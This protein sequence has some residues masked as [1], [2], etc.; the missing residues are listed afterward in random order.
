MYFTHQIMV[1]YVASVLKKKRGGKIKA[2]QLVTL[3]NKGLQP[4]ERQTL[5]RVGRPIYNQSL[6]VLYCTDYRN[7]K[8]KKICLC[9]ILLL[10]AIQGSKKSS[11]LFWD[12]YSTWRGKP[13]MGPTLKQSIF[14]FYNRKVNNLHWL[15]EPWSNCWHARISQECLH[16]R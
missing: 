6:H 13:C 14:S 15:V 5:V 3:A 1:A 12:F 10:L 4:R 8:L 9:Y 7:Y 2:T 16:I 11:P